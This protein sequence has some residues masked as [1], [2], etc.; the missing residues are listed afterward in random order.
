MLRFFKTRFL[1]YGAYKGHFYGTS[2][3]AVKDVLNSGRICVID[4]EPHVSPP[5]V[6]IS[7]ASSLTWPYCGVSSVLTSVASWPGLH[8]K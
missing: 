6:L 3:D 8:C 4:I 2:L 5:G 1:E 7:G